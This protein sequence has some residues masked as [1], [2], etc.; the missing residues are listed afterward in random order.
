[1]KE[2]AIKSIY[3]LLL[4]GLYIACSKDERLLFNEATS[5]YFNTGNTAAFNSIDSLDYSFALDPA[6]YVRDTIYLGVRIT[7]MASDRDRLV[8]ITTDSTTD[9]KWGYHFE[10]LNPFV[11]AGKYEADIPVVVHR[12]PG[13]Q[14]SLV[15]AYFRIQDSED[16]L[17]GYDDVADQWPVF[18]KKYSRT[19]FKL[20]ITDMLV[21]PANWDNL[22]K[23]D[24]GEYSAVKIR[25][26]T[27][28]TGYTNWSSNPFPQDKSFIIQSAKYGLYLYELENGWLIDENGDRVTFN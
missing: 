3:G 23:P 16:L 11:P 13:L 2:I 24:F 21:K 8:N 18:R 10:V 6:D 27:S 17:A 7:G 14:D 25:F 1:M 26:L 12:R 28:V 9:A 4:V 20:T 22:W 5:V 15:T 19:R